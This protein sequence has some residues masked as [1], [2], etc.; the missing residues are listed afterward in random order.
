MLYLFSLHGLSC[1]VIGIIFRLYFTLRMDITLNCIV[2]IIGYFTFYI[3][4][5]NSAVYLFTKITA[6]IQFSLFKLD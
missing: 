6:L 2:V 1:K 4:H 5:V 3:F